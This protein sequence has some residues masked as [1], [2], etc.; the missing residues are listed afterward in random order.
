MAAERCCSPP[1]GHLSVRDTPVF[2]RRREGPGSLA[3]FTTA[4]NAAPPCSRSDR[5][6]GMPTAGR[7]WKTTRHR[8]CPCRDN[9]GNRNGSI[10]SRRRWWAELPPELQQRHCLA[11]KRETQEHG[12]SF[13]GDNHG[14]GDLREARGSFKLR[15]LFRCQCLW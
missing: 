1:T 5:C 14:F 6:V 15:V 13:I 10:G 3:T 12:A 9:P 8:T 7:S 11:R 4:L 2:L